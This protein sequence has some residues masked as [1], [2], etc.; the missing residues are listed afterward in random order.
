LGH[1]AFFCSSW[2]KKVITPQTFNRR[3]FDGA[4]FH[5]SPTAKICS[6]HQESINTSRVQLITYRIHLTK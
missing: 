4:F 3:S 1:R 2:G 5:L 6:M